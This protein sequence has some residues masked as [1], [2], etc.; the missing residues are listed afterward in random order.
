MG[1]IAA[2]V[3]QR[4][5][6]QQIAQGG[7]DFVLA[8]KE[9]QG[10]RYESIQDLFDGAEAWDFDGVPYDHTETMDSVG[11]SAGN[12]GASPSRTAWTTSTHRGNG[13]N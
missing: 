8:V 6:A 2:M 4:E 5:I 13:R 1:T 12:A 11:R 7:A 3:S 9:N 10:Q